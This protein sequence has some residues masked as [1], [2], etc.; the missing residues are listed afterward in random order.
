MS[1]ERPVETVSVHLLAFPAVTASALYGF[2]D[3]FTTVGVAWP[4]LTGRASSPVRFDVKI[5][6]ETADPFTCFG[7]VPVQPHCGFDDVTTADVVI[8][9]DPLIPCTIDP[10]GQ[11]PGIVEWLR[12]QHDNGA[13]LCSVCTGSLL[14]AETGLLDGWQATTH[15][16]FTG[17]FQKYYRKIELLPEHILLS[18]GPDQRLLT[19]GGVASWQDLALH[20]VARFCG[21]AEA[22]RTAK[23][24]VLGDRTIGQLAFAAMPR[25]PDHDDQVIAGCQA[26]IAEHYCLPNAVAGMVARSGLPERTFKRRFKAATG[27]APIRYVQS[28]RVEEAKRLLEATDQTS[29]RVGAD[30]GYEDPASFRRLFKRETNLTPTQYRKHYRG[31]GRAEDARGPLPRVS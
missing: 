4:M 27:Y 25:S 13:L 23:V 14:M 15:W 18:T 9:P 16:A 6:A 7:G 28:M 31:I 21:Q 11:W 12:V 2:Y 19:G 29:E 26:W 5:V 1:Q 30:V 10:R 17:M 8:V 3:I 22:I 24:F 20:V